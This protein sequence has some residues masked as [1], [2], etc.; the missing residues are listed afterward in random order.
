MCNEE[1]WEVCNSLKDRMTQD[2]LVTCP[3]IFGYIN[4]LCNYPPNKRCE[5]LDHLIKIFGL[6]SECG[7]NSLRKLI[8]D[9]IDQQFAQAHMYG[10]SEEGKTPRKFN[11]Y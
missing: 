6:Y 4:G 11:C 1:F 3:D 10:P 7:C 2:D 8:R 9:A 5:L